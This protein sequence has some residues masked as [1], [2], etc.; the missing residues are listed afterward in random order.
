MKLCSTSAFQIRF[1]IKKVT[2]YAILKENLPHF[3]TKMVIFVDEIAL[4]DQM[5]I[6]IRVN[7]TF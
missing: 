5:T 6:R 7:L 4:F 3:V 2:F 1:R